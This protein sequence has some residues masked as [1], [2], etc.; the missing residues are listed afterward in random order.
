MEP[1]AIATLLTGFALGLKHATDADHVVAVSNLV[2]VSEKRTARDGCATGAWWGLGHLA[3]MLAA[4]GVVV[5]LRVRVP[6]RVE[7]LLELGVACVLVWLGVNTVRKCLA[8]QYHFHA[9]QHGGRVHAHFHFHRLD[10]GKH[11]HARHASEAARDFPFAISNLRG[12][13]KP[14]LV[15]MMHGLSGTAGLALVVLGSIPSRALGITYLLVFGAGALAGMAAFGAVLSW[16]LGRAAGRMQWMKA[17]QMTAG[18]GSA[19]FGAFLIQQALMPGAW[20]F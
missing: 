12:N 19:G 1:A 15:G 14:L 20:P 18:T 13:A 4:G 7:W 2:S 8:G 3:T 5:G 6:T 10:A 9:H 16:P 11:E 17:I